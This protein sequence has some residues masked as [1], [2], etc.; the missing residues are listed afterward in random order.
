MNPSLRL[1]KAQGPQTA[2]EIEAM[3]SVPYAEAVSSLLYLARGT[4][5][6]I[7]YS[8]AFMSRFVANLGRAHWQ[9]VKH[10]FRYLQGT[11]DLRL[12]YRGDQFNAQDVFRVFTDAA[13]GDSIDTGRSTS[14]YLLTI[15]GGAV[16][17]S[18]RPSVACGAVHD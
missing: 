6:D 2:E 1:S 5:P 18:S 7:A 8:V 11:K 14:G 16:S 12:V 15:G 13:H 4:R 3:R 10:L 9:A 17:W